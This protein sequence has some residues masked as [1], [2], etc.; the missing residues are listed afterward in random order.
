M[1]SQPSVPGC[2]SPDFSGTQAQ[3]QTFLSYVDFYDRYRVLDEMGWSAV[4]AFVPGIEIDATP[5]PMFPRPF[6]LHP[7]PYGPGAWNNPG[8]INQGVYCLE[9]APAG[10]YSN[11][12][13]TVYGAGL[14]IDSCLTGTGDQTWTTPEYGGGPGTLWAVDGK[15]ADNVSTPPTGACVEVGGWLPGTSYG[16]PHAEACSGS[17]GEQWQIE[18]DGHIAWAKDPSY[19][20]AMPSG[21]P[22]GQAPV[23]APCAN[24]PSQIWSR[25]VPHL[26]P[27]KL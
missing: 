4:Q 9:D 24:T 13:G 16:P 2:I 7:Q 6:P 21:N 22:I 23:M 27:I 3:A 1:A 15:V 10:Y 8:V 18:Q 12:S 17:P 26:V 25:G 19:C 20:L 5:P 14:I 11:G